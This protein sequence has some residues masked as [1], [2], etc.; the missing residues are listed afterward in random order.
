MNLYGYVG[1]DPMNGTDPSG[2]CTGSNL[3]NDDGSCV[4]T[5]GNTTGLDGVAQGAAREKAFDEVAKR[6]LPDASTKQQKQLGNALLQGTVNSERARSAYNN[7]SGLR[8]GGDYAGYDIGSYIRRIKRF[9]G[10][11][12]YQEGR[13][14]IG[15]PE[16]RT[17]GEDCGGGGSCR[18]RNVVAIIVAPTPDG[19]RG[20]RV[21]QG[22]VDNK[23]TR[24]RRNYARVADYIGAPVVIITPEYLEIINP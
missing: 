13:A 12:K 9:F 16:G 2:M 6:I 24:Q 21:T 17:D 14:G 7:R 8:R 1:N 20:G 11:T 15:P 3:S 18:S 23:V 5:G 10:G 4:S 22:G 19:Y